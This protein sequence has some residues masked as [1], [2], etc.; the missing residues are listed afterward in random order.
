MLITAGHSLL[1]GPS[2]ALH[3]IF[4]WN[5][6]HEHDAGVDMAE[7]ME[8]NEWEAIIL[9]EA[10]QAFEDI[11]GVVGV[12]GAW[13]QGFYFIE[14]IGWARDYAGRSGAFCAFGDIFIVLVL[15][16]SALDSDGGVGEVKIF[17]GQ[18]D[19]FGAA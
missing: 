15:N 12:Y 14:D 2:A 4:I 1:G 11:A 6:K 8:A 19:D 5:I 13:G 10:V 16:D 3:G 18:G 7:I 17:A 9:A